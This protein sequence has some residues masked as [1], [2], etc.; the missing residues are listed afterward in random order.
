MSTN[1]PFDVERIRADFPILHQ[2][3][4]ENRPLVYLDNAAT[5]Q[6]PRAVIAALC[7]YY[8][9]YNANVHRALHYLGEQATARFEEARVKM[10]RFI[11]AASE[12]EVV[13]TRGTTESI[14]LIAYAW[15]HEHVQ[16]GDEIIATAMEHHSNL[17]PWQQLCAARGAT[18]KL[19][20]ITDRGELDMDAFRALLTERVK[21]VTV[22]HMSNVLGTINPIPEIVAA[23]RNV[24]ALVLVDAAQSVPHGHVNVQ[25]LG[26][27]FVV[28]SGHKMCAPTGVGVLWAPMRHLQA[29]SPFLAGGEMI[30]K[31]H[32]DHAT[33][34]EVPYK[35][36]AGT[37]NIADVIA[38][39]AAVDYL[40]SIGM[41]AIHAHEKA[42]TEYAI[43]QLSELPGVRVFGLA[44]TRGGAVSFETLGIH[45]HDLSQYVDQQGI[46]IRAGHL[47]AQP[48][49]RRLGVP[50]VSRASVYLYNRHDEIDELVSAIQK[51]Q[52]FFGHG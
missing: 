6:K 52:R 18:L 47:C 51:A 1:T 22:T 21:L 25:E 38:L 41:D 29:M 30:S 39:G 23:A 31:V 45:P 17:V 42:L 5:S 15:G 48:L 27:D 37:P 24:G 16:A 14:N 40:E 8:E 50:A 20:P 4:Y 13:F 28:F 3:V 35:F 26:A 11:G 44:S 49:M 43:A 7:E 10:A 36:E 9:R 2:T 12:R 33:W 46:A 34:A 19:A 32:D